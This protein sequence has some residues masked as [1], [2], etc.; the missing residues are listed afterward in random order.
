VLRPGG[1]YLAQH[2]GPRS[3]FELIERFV[4]SVPGPAARDPDDEAAAAE[5]A[6]L[7]VEDLRR[8]AC[9]M[10][11][12]DVGAVIWILRK[13]VWW[14]PGFSVQRYERTLRELDAEMRAGRPVVAHST[15]HL[16]E[17]R[18]PS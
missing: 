18:R 11:F 3:A 14:V 5:R 9:R 6:G 1:T 13:C 15:R 12:F 10:A 17:A 4:G 2:V 8:A 7:V 16:V